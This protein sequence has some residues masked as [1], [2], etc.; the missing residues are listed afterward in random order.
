MSVLYQNTTVIVAPILKLAFIR[1]VWE[2]KIFQSLPFFYHICRCVAIFATPTKTLMCILMFTVTNIS[3]FGS[4]FNI[5][6]AK[7]VLFLRIANCLCQNT[8][9][10]LVVNLLNL[11]VLDDI[12][13][14]KLLSFFLKMVVTDN[15]ASKDLDIEKLRT[16]ASNETIAVPFVSYSQFSGFVFN[17]TDGYHQYAEVVRTPYLDCGLIMLIVL[18]QMQVVR[19]RIISFGLQRSG[20]TKIIINSVG[21]QLDLLMVLTSVDE[22]NGFAVYENIT[23][24]GAQ[25]S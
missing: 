13:V 6:L 7:M 22:T 16:V 12:E 19:Q 1:G 10:Q 18:N 8:N 2:L 11:Y 14:Y 20:V 21:I 3:G 15:V 9:L 25:V 24:W 5:T 17:G 23:E 4:I